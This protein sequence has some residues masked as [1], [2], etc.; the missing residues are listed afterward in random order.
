MNWLNAYAVDWE[1]ADYSGNVYLRTIF[2]APREN[3]YAI[4]IEQATDSAQLLSPNF[5]G[6]GNTINL[7]GLEGMA[8]NSPDNPVDSLQEIFNLVDTNAVCVTNN[9]MQASFWWNPQTIYNYSG[10][11][12]IMV[13]S[14]VY[15]SVHGATQGLIAD[16]TCIGYGH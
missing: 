11:G 13:G 2:Y 8:N 3:G 7:N 4:K 5:G 1:R 16:S 6:Q 10:T 14:N 15:R 12:T 9:G